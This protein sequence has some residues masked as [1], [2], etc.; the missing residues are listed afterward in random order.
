MKKDLLKVSAVILALTSVLSAASCGEVGDDET[1]SSKKKK[2]SSQ[3]M[4]VIEDDEDE[5]EEATDVKTEKEYETEEA[6]VPEETA[7]V[8]AETEIKTEPEI[9]A[10]T[11]APSK[12]SAEEVHLKMG[13]SYV[14]DDTF[15][16]TIT[17]VEE[18]SHRNQYGN[19]EPQAVYEVSYTYSN[20]GY[21]NSFGEGLYLDVTD[22]IVDSTGMMGYGYT[23]DN[24][25]YPRYAPVGATCSCVRGVGV[26][27]AGSFDLVINAYDK[28]YNKKSATITVD[29]NDHN[30]YEAPENP[31]KFDTSNS[32]H[33][34][35][36][37]TVPN[38]CELTIT[39]VE[40]IADRNQYNSYKPG[41]VYKI[42]YTYKNIGYESDIMDGLYMTINE[43]VISSTGA[44]GKSYSV[45]SVK[46]PQAV[47]KNASC[48]AEAVVGLD[49]P[50][51]F[52]IIVY[53]YDNDSKK[54]SAVFTITP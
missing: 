11:N 8:P 54:H 39:G 19:K 49:A 13:E 41:A 38:C 29:V 9:P 30:K 2:S 27:N 18:S 40:E 32:L 44:V 15:I 35:D 26:D 21:T 22:M 10:E 23:T 50:G 14:L 31:V 37:W 20:I 51:E 24:E 28:E 7:E 3:P 34:G 5:T 52:S 48:N 36:T 4:Y 42:A 43:T 12:P 33:I 53:Q 17:G 1:G 46:S 47:P 45:G 25:I 6:T 16:L